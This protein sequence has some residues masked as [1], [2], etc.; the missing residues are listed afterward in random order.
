MK[1]IDKQLKE[2]MVAFQQY[3]RTD[4]KLLKNTKINIAFK[5]GTEMR[6]LHRTTPVID[7]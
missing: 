1:T 3:T 7:K 4:I 5:T 6:N 2:K